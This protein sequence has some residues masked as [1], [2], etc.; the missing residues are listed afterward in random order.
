MIPLPLFSRMYTY[1]GLAITWSTQVDPGMIY[2]LYKHCRSMKRFLS[3][4]GH[5][6]LH[7]T[8]TC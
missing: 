2:A 4:W 8:G 7:N 5:N 6:L 1:I 3:K